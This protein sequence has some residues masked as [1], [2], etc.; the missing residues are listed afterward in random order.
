MKSLCADRLARMV[1]CAAALVVAVSAW[2]AAAG[3]AIDLSEATVVVRGQAAPLVEQTAATVLVEEIEKR[4]GLRWMIAE[5]WPSKGP[6]VGITSGAA[7]LAGKEIPADLVPD[8]AEGCGIA[9]D[10]SNT[11]AVVWV[12]GSDPKGA[13]NGVG[14]LL[15]SIDWRKGA[16]G[17]KQ[18]LHVKAAPRA[19]IRGHQLGYRST[20]NSY[21]A[22]DAAQYDQYIR[23]MSFFGLNAIENIPFE[24][25][26]SP[27]MPISPR[28][29]N[30]ELGSICQK[31]GVAY[32]VWTPAEVDLSDSAKRAELLDR[33][34][35]FYKDSTHLDAVFFPGGDP[36]HNHPKLMMP[37]LEDAS[38]RLAKHHPDVKVWMSLQGFDEEET[39]YY[40]EWLAEHQPDWFGGAVG[41]PSSPPLATLRAR[42]HEKYQLRDYPDIT[43]TVRSQYPTA[44]IDP[45][46]AHT[47]GR[48]G[49]N[50]EPV[51]YSIIHNAT[52]PYTDGF[53]TY[54]D[55]MHDDVNKTVYSAFGWNPDSDLRDV[56]VDYC[57]VFFG[58]DVA[59]RA[60]DGIFALEQ[61][62]SGPLATNGGVEATLALWQSLEK[63]APELSG[64][65]RWQLCLMK[66]NYDAYVR[67]RL[68]HEEKLELEAN[69]ALAE[70]PQIGADAAMDRALSILTRADTHIQR[71]DVRERVYQLCDDL[72]NS[73]GYQSSVK[74]YGCS[75]PQR[76]DVLD[77]VEHPLNSR[78]WLEDEFAKVRAMGSEAEKVARLDVLRTWEHPGPGSFYDDIGNVG[79]SPHVIRG[80][81]LNTDPRMK[82]NPNPDFMWWDAGK[83]RVR[84]SWISKMDWPIGLRYE[85]LDANADYVVRTTGLSQCLL[86]VN[87]ERVQPTIDGKEVGEIKE[88]P[89]PRELYRDGLIIL[90]FDFPHEPGINWRQ[91]S[92][93]S[94][95]WLIK[96]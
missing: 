24:E 87:G 34:E 36:G 40:F 73:I 13:L 86:R 42:L 59:E 67:A 4:T 32:W 44:W 74:K 22:W 11:N 57:R 21:D 5:Q 81:G 41:G 49:T 50:P 95:V 46:F 28:E 8:K 88:F 55:G 78:W 23:E 75:R 77:H 63:Q 80:E 93:L 52:A 1:C 43:H 17:L 7:A 92:R 76:S 69:D 61:N 45:A 35:A 85:G 47:S 12:V 20:A 31:Y 18:P 70:A 54:S 94:E 16:A 89:V 25:K 71:S 58:P 65:W 19:A 39:D 60:A 48:E 3:E 6:A 79:K 14:K 27:H 51:Y 29:M 96:R 66:A 33:H 68:I 37:F 83:S 56:L 84:P 9:T 15:R 10:T 72:F 38:K 53:V 91:A 90:T 26:D 82:R 64:N 62:W 30:R 2:T